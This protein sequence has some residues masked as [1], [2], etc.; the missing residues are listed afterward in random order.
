MEKEHFGTFLRRARESRDLVLADVALKT[1]VARSTLELLES[2]DLGEL[3]AGVYVRGFIRSFARA[4]GADETEPLLMYERA[5]EAKSRA[6]KKR[7]IT[8]VAEVPVDMGV[9]AEFSDEGMVPRRGLGLAVFV[10]IL[11]LIATITLSLLL[12]RP[13]PSG[14]GLSLA[15]PPPA[16][17]QSGRPSLT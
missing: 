6:E 5:V 2:G 12:R 4:V 17:V 14:E 3:P 16:T 15:P 11:L 1:K 7:E 10:I 8:P 13:P 9:P